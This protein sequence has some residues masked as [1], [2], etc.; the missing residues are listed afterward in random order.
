[1]SRITEVLPLA[2]AFSMACGDVSVETPL[3]NP[4]KHQAKRG[5]PVECGTFIP[6]PT[7]EEYLSKQWDQRTDAYQ[8]AV[9]SKTIPEVVAIAEVDQVH[10]ATKTKLD[11]KDL[12]VST[13]TVDEDKPPPP[14]QAVLLKLISRLSIDGDVSNLD[15]GPKGEVLRAAWMSSFHEDEF[16]RKDAKRRYD[17]FQNER[18]K[19]SQE[20]IMGKWFVFELDVI[21]KEYDFSAQEY[22]WQMDG[23][24]A[25]K[26]RGKRAWLRSGQGKSWPFVSSTKVMGWNY[27]PGPGGRYTCDLDDGIFSEYNPE[28]SIRLNMSEDR[29]RKVSATVK[30]LQYMQV[31]ATP[32]EVTIEETPPGFEGHMGER[33]TLMVPEVD[34]L[35]W[36]L[37]TSSS[38]QPDFFPKPVQLGSDN[39]TEWVGEGFSKTLDVTQALSK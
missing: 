28:I 9:R 32:T 10:W 14:V 8:T 1:M 4:V 3:S 7:V 19:A 23:L 12:A 21:P 18:K 29:A 16:A 30:S 13:W 15:L 24:S 31:M 39:C 27:P 17:S 35:A 38:A 20:R 34:I 36:R 33:V 26:R 6:D 22:G 37:C 25:H 5:D 11:F 2:F